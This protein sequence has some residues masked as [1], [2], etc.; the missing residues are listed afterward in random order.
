[1][2]AAVF[3]DTSVLLLAAGRSADAAACAKALRDWQS[4]AVEVHLAAETVQ[5]F[6]V[7]RTRIG[8]ERRAIAETP[9]L[10]SASVVHATDVDVL[11]RDLDLM[12]VGLRGRDAMIAATPLM[13][14]F[15]EIVSTDSDFDTTPGLR[16]VDPRQA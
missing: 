4:E 15:E 1:M 11:D 8:H 13:A 5:E 14:G 6:V 10:A 9:I 16:R 3:V 7:H 12:E 2:T